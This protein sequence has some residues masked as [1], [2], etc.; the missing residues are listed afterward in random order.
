[1]SHFANAD[2]VDSSMCDTQVEKF[3]QMDHLISQ[4]GFSPAH[5]HIS[6]SAGIAKIQD[7]H[8]T[9]CRSGIAFYGYSPLSETDPYTERFTDL[10]PALR[11]ESTV[12]ALQRI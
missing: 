4:Y 6:N 12:V 1:M 10:T 11:V 8:F 5:K 7:P 3:K 2:E 9:A